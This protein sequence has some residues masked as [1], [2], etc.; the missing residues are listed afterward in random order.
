MGEKICNLGEFSIGFNH[1]EIELNIS[2]NEKSRNEIHI[3]S[4]RFRAEMSED[5]LLILAAAFL[6]AERKLKIHKGF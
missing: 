5:E 1:F 3:Q 4:R 6:L 2:P